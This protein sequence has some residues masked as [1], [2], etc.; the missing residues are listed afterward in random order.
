MKRP[1]AST[2][3]WLVAGL[4]LAAALWP[5]AAGATS[6]VPIAVPDLA[7]AAEVVVLGTVRSTRAER[8]AGGKT[9]TAVEVKVLKTLKGT[10]PPGSVIVRQLGGLVAGGG[11]IVAG[12]PTFSPGECVLLFLRREG[13]DLRLVGEAQGKFRVGR[14]QGT[15][16]WTA[17][18]TEPDTGRVLDRIPLD[19]IK[20]LLAGP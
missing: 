2:L 11:S 1:C 3:R 17:T 4:L 13:G 12:A 18:R 15:S 7:R 16:A 8:D 20:Q 10:H 14:D 5:P 19:S 9:S 6:V